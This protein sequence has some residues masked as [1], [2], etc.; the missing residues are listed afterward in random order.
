MKHEDVVITC[1]TAGC[2]CLSEAVDR[3]R[4]LAGQ[5]NVFDTYNLSAKF[6]EFNRLYFG[7][8]LPEIPCA[9][10]KFKGNVSGECRY[11]LKFPDGYRPNPTLKRISL[12]SYYR[13]AVIVPGSMNIRINTTFK[14]TEARIDGIFIH[15][16]I[17]A[18]LA[19]IG[20]HEG[21][22]HGASFRKLAKEIGDQRGQVIPLT[23]SEKADLNTDVA[24]SIGVLFYTMGND[25]IAAIGTPKAAEAAV[26]PVRAA[27]ARYG[28]SK[29]DYKIV[30]VSSLAWTAESEKRPV[31]RTLGT[32]KDN[33]FR[34]TDPQQ[35]KDLED[36]KVLLHIPPGTKPS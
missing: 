35:I 28:V 12:N 10:E 17:H 18:H 23:D 11:S 13:D 4:T 3:I 34:V 21:G 8:K 9:F 6:A 29:D 32:Y 31:Q 2:G 26:E 20:D 22:N 27:R 24:K 19:L 7:N 30:I 15:E 36:A 5:G 33:R 1:S 25:I 16:M 14:T